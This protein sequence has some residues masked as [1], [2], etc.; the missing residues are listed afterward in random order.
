M[1]NQD[2]GPRPA[3]GKWQRGTTAVLYLLY[4][5]WALALLWDFAR[6]HVPDSRVYA[7]GFDWG[8]FG[9]EGLGTTLGVLMGLF[10]AVGWLLFLLVFLLACWGL[11]RRLVKGREGALGHFFS[12]GLGL[13]LLS[14]LVLL[15]GYLGLYRGYFLKC[16]FLLLLV[17]AALCLYRRRPWREIRLGLGEWNWLEICLLVFLVVS[18]LLNYAW[19][20]GP[21]VFYDSLVYHLAIPDYYLAQ[22]RVVGMPFNYFSNFPLGSEMI[23]LLALATG[24]EQLAML[25]NWSYAVLAALLLFFCGRRLMMGRAASLIAALV[26]YNIPIVAVFSWQVSA[27]NA[28]A[29]YLVLALAALMFYLE[30]DDRPALAYAAL[31]L[32]FACG[33]KYLGL[34]ALAIF[35][36]CLCWMAWR[37]GNKGVLVDGCMLLFVSLVVFSPWLI[38]NLA[39]TGNPLFPFFYEYLGGRNLYALGMAEQM[40]EFRE[41]GG[42]SLGAYLASF[43]RLTAAGGHSNGF[44]G[45][46]FLG[47]LPLLLALRRLR[48]TLGF[49]LFFALAYLLV[50]SFHTQILR[51]YLMGAAALSLAVG[52]AYEQMEDGATGRIGRILY[53]PAIFLLL[54]QLAF[55]LHKTYEL[56]LLNYDRL[57]VFC[58]SEEETHY[59]YRRLPFSG[60]T[61]A[62]SPYYSVREYVNSKL[63]PAARLLFVGEA[64]GYG[65][66]RDYRAG[67]AFDH[68]P[69]LAYRRGAADAAELYGA[70]RADG[71]SHLLFSRGE[72]GRLARGYSSY[73]WPDEL[74]PLAREFWRKHLRSLFSS[75]GVELYELVAEGGNADAAA[76]GV[77]GN[78]AVKKGQV[79]LQ[80]RQLMMGGKYAEARRIYE[81][82]LEG[83]QA[84]VELYNSLGY[85]CLM[86]GEKRQARECLEKALEL[87]PDDKVLRDNLRQL[88]DLVGR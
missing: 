49:V 35:F 24:G 51:Y 71:F 70:L 11:G 81:A 55:N 29:L 53:A 64:R 26:F 59:S 27:D 34:Y 38:K 52:M 4:F 76:L 44:L 25:V 88:E 73:S 83:G 63:P 28:L 65:F 84:N 85:A 69:F 12:L 77:L 33:V 20:L 1:D 66:E 8:R 47:A 3:A 15:L 68:Q 61:A 40:A 43:W 72:A 22:G 42:R 41:V 14:L 57:G 75:Y 46:L 32:G 56:Y 7:A 62:I 79:M 50:W 39:L 18:F 58:G 48:R 30:E 80:A 60:K 9:P 78:A 21:E 6:R 23:A 19:A 16:L 87:A 36:A 13:G 86:T 45:C 54:C 37:R 31:F 82:L 74:L 10:F 67:T 5:P 2:N 17:N